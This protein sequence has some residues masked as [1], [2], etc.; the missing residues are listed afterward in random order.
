[1]KL[2]GTSYATNLRTRIQQACEV[3]GPVRLLKLGRRLPP[4]P[5]AELEASARQSKA[6]AKHL[7]LIHCN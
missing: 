6:N 4:G 1:M 7:L 3:T 2:F 5:L